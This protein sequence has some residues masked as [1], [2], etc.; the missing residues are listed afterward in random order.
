MQIPLQAFQVPCNLDCCKGDL[1][2]SVITFPEISCV[3]AH[4]PAQFA[5]E[6]KKADKTVPRAIVLSM[7]LTAVL[8]FAFLLAIL[9]SMQVC[10]FL[11]QEDRRLPA[12]RIEQHASHLYQ[13]A[14]ICAQLFMWMEKALSVGCG[15]S[16]DTG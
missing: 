2:Y 12:S 15:Y 7:I 6:T 3:H 4:R 11:T 5:E 14:A 1:R 10:C 16:C 9:F 13:D 8:G